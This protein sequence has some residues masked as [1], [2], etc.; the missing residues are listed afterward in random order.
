MSEPTL[1]N[2]TNVTPNASPSVPAPSR[3]RRAME[4]F[5]RARAFLNSGGTVTKRVELGLA[6]SL[7]VGVVLAAGQSWRPAV[8]APA[9]ADTVMV[10]DRC[11]SATLVPLSGSIWSV[12]PWSEDTPVTLDELRVQDDATLERRYASCAVPMLLAPAAATGDT[13]LVRFVLRHVKATERQPFLNDAMLRA[14]PYPAVTGLLLQAGAA[15]P[16]L[17]DA[18]RLGAKNALTFALAHTRSQSDL[19]EA[20]TAIANAPVRDAERSAMA[21]E[22]FEHGARAAGDTLSA[23]AS[24]VDSSERVGLFKLALQHRQPGAVEHAFDSVAPG[25]AEVF[26]Q[27]L[28]AEGIDWGYRD[29]EDDAAMPLV[30]TISHGNEQAARFLVAHGAP[31]NRFYKDG[32]SALHAAVSCTAGAVCGRMVELLLDHGADPNRRFLDGTTPLFAAAEAGDGRS[33]RAL[34]D[35]GARID[36]RVVR[37]TAIDVAEDNGNDTAA[38]ILFARGARLSPSRAPFAMTPP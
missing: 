11:Q 20:L 12:K 14:D 32:S 13:H 8:A 22:L 16:S 19:D 5:A 31:V 4:S 1:E 37:R 23:I 10:V 21:E 6:V 18:A 2:D 9:V 28:V 38:R 33:I 24:G 7:S 34:L 35:H 30:T 15:R 25:T 36:E 26:L 29:G 27:L 3:L 17:V